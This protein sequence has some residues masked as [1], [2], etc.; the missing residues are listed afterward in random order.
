MSEFDVERLEST[1]TS[2]LRLGSTEEGR[3]GLPRPSPSGKAQRDAAFRNCRTDRGTK[4]A[5]MIT[6]QMNV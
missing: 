5:R 6:T 4:T 1:P 3:G 2:E